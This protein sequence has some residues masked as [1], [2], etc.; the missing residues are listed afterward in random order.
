MYKNIDV[1][2]TDGDGQAHHLIHSL[3]ETEITD[4][5]NAF[6]EYAALVYEGSDRAT[7]AQIDIIYVERPLTSL[8]E[9]GPNLWWPS[10]ADTAPELNSY[11]T[12]TYDSVLI[13][14]PQTNFNRATNPFILGF[15]HGSIPLVGW[16][17]LWHS[18]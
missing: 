12:D 13:L 17:D 9:L 18:C 14:W 1:S 4:G 3:P 11:V 15:G 8:S 5:V 2:Y 7:F 10:P 6:R 16:G